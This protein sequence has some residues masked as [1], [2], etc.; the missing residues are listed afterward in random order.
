MLRWSAA[1]IFVALIQCSAPAQKNEPLTLGPKQFASKIKSD[2]SVVVIDV[3]TPA[4]V[5]TGTLSGALKL[6]FNAEDFQKRI[7]ALD[8]NKTYLVYCAAG[9]RS[10]KAAAQMREKG[11]K[12]VISLEGGINAWRANGLPVEQP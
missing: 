7:E 8:R 12:H 3:R 11:F 9:V 5:A 6:D 4:E 10:G 2:P 1:V